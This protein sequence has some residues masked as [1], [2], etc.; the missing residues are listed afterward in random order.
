MG[1]EASSPSAYRLGPGNRRANMA[2]G[3]GPIGASR[4]CRGIAHVLA[5]IWRGHMELFIG[6]SFDSRG[7]IPEVGGLARAVSDLSPRHNSIGRE[8]AFLGW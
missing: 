8:L 2:G 4:R 5:M 7:I 1:G 6:K 3:G